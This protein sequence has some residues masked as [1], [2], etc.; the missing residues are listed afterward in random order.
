MQQV[1]NPCAQVPDCW[2]P[3]P[4]HSDWNDHL[5]FTK[6]DHSSH[7]PLR[8]VPRRLFVARHSSLGNFVIWNILN[9]KWEK[10]MKGLIHLANLMSNKVFYLTL[11]NFEL[12]KIVTICSSFFKKFVPSLLNSCIYKS[13][14]L[15]K[16]FLL[17]E[18]ICFSCQLWLF[19]IKIDI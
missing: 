3:K 13:K 5:R 6:L 15:V 18:N 10:T 12:S 11:K 2:P 14:I 16:F 1:P 8:Q 7:T 4:V 9:P 17:I 19:E